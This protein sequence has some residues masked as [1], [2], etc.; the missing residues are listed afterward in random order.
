MS[1]SVQAGY[2]KRKRLAAA[3]M[4]LLGISFVALSLVLFLPG[5]KREYIFA[6]GSPTGLYHSIASD[7]AGIVNKE[8]DFRVSVVSSHGSGD[9][10]VRLE[11]S[12]CDFALLQND[13]H[14]GGAVRSIGA[15]YSEHLHLLVR[16]GAGIACFS[17]LAGKR[18][19]IG[20]SAG[21][22]VELARALL[23][24]AFASESPPK[25]ILEMEAAAG[26][27]ALR[28]GEL[29]AMFLVAGLRSP[30]IVDSLQ[31]AELELLPLS[32]QATDS[33]SNAAALIDGL[34]TIYP[35]VQPSHIPMRTYGRVPDRP[36]QTLC[37]SSVLVCRKDV[38][39]DVVSTV[40]ATLFQYR[41]ELSRNS[42][43]LAGLREESASFD[44]Q[45]P[46]HAGA[47][48]FY[49]RTEPSF[50]ARHAESM[51]F[52]LTVALLAGSAVKGLASWRS[53]LTKDYI[54]IYF[55]RLSALGA[56]FERSESRQQLNDLARQVT[57]LE[58]EASQDL[59][60]E[61]LRPDD[62]FV[63]LLQMSSSLRERIEFRTNRIS[64]GGR[65]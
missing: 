21:G 17:D 50:L 12:Q 52:L 63:I 35:H 36:L 6:S 38:P 54:D 16:R 42:P 3:G 33:A 28:A 55:Q 34:Q 62:S 49:H 19:S 41:A 22:T 37:V 44:L 9:N 18:V 11:Q 4:L 27:T 48:D 39:A 31:G 65:S 43:V 61:E 2:R 8:S 15:L 53:K 32:L 46:L 64:E 47:D 1:D 25:Q 26:F 10:A 56:E 29:D 60:A 13:T 30:E 45:F 51:G 14:C 58:N 59:V 24:F 5:A 23:Q 40:A 57:E 7:L 20:D